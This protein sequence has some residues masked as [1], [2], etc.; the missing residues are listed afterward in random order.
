MIIGQPTP[1][2]EA[3]K[4]A[5]RK[6]LLPTD[7]TSAELHALAGELKRRAVFSSRLAL[8]DPLQQLQDDL[9]QIVS[10]EKDPAGVLRSIPEAKARL[11][12]A[13][14]NAGYAAPEGKEGTLLDHLSDA[15]RQL[16]VET[17]VLD[18]LNFGRFQKS[19]NKVTLEVLPAWELVRMRQPRKPEWMRDW[20]ERWEAA[21]EDAGDEGCTAASSGRL[22]ALKNHPIWAALGDGAGGYQDTLGNPWPPFAFHS[23]MNWINI[24]RDTAIELGL[25]SDDDTIEPDDSHNLN[26][27]LQGSVARFGELLIKALFD[28]QEF[29]LADGILTLSGA[30]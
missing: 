17:N 20:D 13:L 30:A 14:Q 8:A 19:Q 16:I 22:V 25:M 15:R 27:G 2:D 4:I 18:T 3:I 26:E 28:H 23:G 6:H 29:K 12:R 24:G 1:F 21:R 11:G 7:L 9:A 5:Q 10:G